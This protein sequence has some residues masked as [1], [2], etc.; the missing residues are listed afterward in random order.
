MFNT[1]SGLT[2]SIIKSSREADENGI[3]EAL[4]YTKAV[5]VCMQ[6]GCLDSEK[7]GQAV[8]NLSEAK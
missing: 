8:K 7:V 2:C 5:H 1:L 6:Q 4:K 3:I